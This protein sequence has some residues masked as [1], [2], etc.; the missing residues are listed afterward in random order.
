MLIVWLGFSVFCVAGACAA[1]QM[2]HQSNS[3]IVPFYVCGV[4]AIMV[5][6]AVSPPVLI[7]SLALIVLGAACRATRA[8]PRR[9][10]QFA[11]AAMGVAYVVCGLIWVPTMRERLAVRDRNPFDSLASRLAYEDRTTTRSQHAIANRVDLHD[12]SALEPRAESPDD[13]ERLTALEDAIDRSEWT[14]RSRSYALRVIHS[15]FVEQFMDA[16]GFGVTRGQ[17]MRVP[18]KYADASEPS[19]IRL[20][21]DTFFDPDGTS[22]DMTSS[23]PASQSIPE[24]AAKPVS[25][26]Q[27]EALHEL[28][29][30]DFVNPRGWGYVINRDRVAGFQAHQ[31]RAL[32]VLP[33]ESEA[34]SSPSEVLSRRAVEARYSERT[35]PTAT[36]ENWQVRRLQLVSLLKHDEPAVYV[37]EELPRMDRLV[38]VPVRSLDAFEQSAL[39]SLDRGGDVITATSDINRIRMFGAIRATNQCLRCHAVERGELL[40]A[41]TYVLE[42]T[43]PVRRSRSEHDRVF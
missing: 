25:K 40:G 2:G 20:P 11:T 5:S 26:R 9:F 38:D 12:A 23:D 6:L 31:F 3:R 4:L 13:S 24:P 15:S 8:S 36:D 37:V 35:V 27:L 10:L 1:Y 34:G 41:F 43:N 33:T 21:P 39:E 32:P 14:W 42:R 29:L 22:S 28:G 30:F 17:Y 7:T 19:L 18:E 16:P